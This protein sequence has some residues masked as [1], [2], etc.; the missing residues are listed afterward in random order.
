MNRY[1]CLPLV[2]ALLLSGC[3]VDDSPQRT[4]QQASQADAETTGQQMT[5]KPESHRLPDRIEAGNSVTP[6][7]AVIDSSVPAK[8]VNKIRADLADRAGA[9]PSQV[10]RELSLL[11][12]EPVVWNDGSLGCP[13]PGEVYTQALVNGYWI[14]L[15]YDGKSWDYRA[16]EKGYFILC[17]GAGR[18]P[19]EGNPR[20]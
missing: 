16:N 14:V 7:P 6:E 12:A 20:M 15:G 17:E 18:P 19:Y 2:A 10:E 4:E 9:P 13:K 3:P 8:L 5:K 11:R 1:A